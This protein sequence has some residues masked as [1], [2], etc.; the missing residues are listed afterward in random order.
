MAASNPTNAVNNSVLTKTQQLS[1]D[2]QNTRGRLMWVSEP[3]S[4]GDTGPF[5]YLMRVSDLTSMSYF[6]K[7]SWDESTGE[8]SPKKGAGSKI[9]LFTFTNPDGTEDMAPLPTAQRQV[10]WLQM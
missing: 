2:R 5:P 7:P 8:H 9:P 1:Q 6:R 4:L 3:E 10:S